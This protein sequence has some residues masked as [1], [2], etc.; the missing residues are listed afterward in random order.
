MHCVEEGWIWLGKLNRYNSFPYFGHPLHFV[1]TFPGSRRVKHK[2]CFVSCINFTFSWVRMPEALLIL[3]D[4]YHRRLDYRLRYYRWQRDCNLSA[5]QVDKV[6][7]YHHLQR[8]D[9]LYACRLI[10]KHGSL[11]HHASRLIL[12][13][14]C[15]KRDY[16]VTLLWWWH[17][18]WTILSS[19][20]DCGSWDTYCIWSNT[21]CFGV[22]DERLSCF[23]TLAHAGKLPASFH[24]YHHYLTFDQQYELIGSPGQRPTKLFW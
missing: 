12:V 10:L 23:G 5:E 11:E 9:R 13:I 16:L 8:I 7:T 20:T 22:F 15:L 18:P 3:A 2:V 17:S 4:G 14:E 24:S 1:L 21:D 19:S 6:L